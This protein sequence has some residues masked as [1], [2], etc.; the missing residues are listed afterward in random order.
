VLTAVFYVSG[1]GFGH[2]S[3][4]VEVINA[5]RV[6][7]PDVR[8]HVR[9]RA[10][11]W[12]FDLTVAGAFEYTAVDTDVGVVQ[13]DALTPDLPA[14][15]DRAAAFHATA[16]ARVAREATALTS[17]GASVVVADAPPIALG[18]AAAAAVPG[19]ALTNFTWDWIYEDYARHLGTHLDLPGRLRALQRR[20]TQAWRL[21]MHGGFEG[22]HVVRDLPLVAR[23]SR[24]DRRDTRRL[25]GWD[26]ER[27]V[28]L[29]SFGGV[30][31]RELPLARVA[32][33]G[34][35]QVVAT[36]DP[37]APRDRG[38]AMVRTEA[39]IAVLDER[40]LYGE[41]L[42]YEDVVAAADVVV[43]KPGY[44]IVSECIAHDTALLY[45]SRGRFA[46]YDVLVDAMPRW[47]RCGFIDQATLLAGD[48][49]PSLDAL[50]A[51][52]DPEATPALDGAE[53]AASWLE[54]FLS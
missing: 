11:R 2:A 47:L 25:L 36:Q 48:W 34:A 41:G 22:L 21:P 13:I 14:T 17:L 31:M 33:G 4:S 7:R 32:A 35:Y 18:A 20:A 5:L 24:R 46:E 37:R 1:H 45:T 51:R 23:R 54:E 53:V 49:R 3:R 52:P 43:T 50:L 42:R 27:P 28:V 29:T 39:G 40:A 26:A 44:G 15:L 30:G 12:L 9:T 10:P 16:E 6:R 19:I 38:A 8:I